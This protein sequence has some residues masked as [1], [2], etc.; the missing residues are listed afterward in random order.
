MPWGRASLEVECLRDGTLDVDLETGE[1]FSVRRGERKKRRLRTDDDGYKSFYLNRERRD[2]RG[3]KEY[4]RKT[5]GFRYRRR[6]LVFVHR[7]V[8][9][10]AIAL[11][12]GGDHNWRDY[13]EDLP[14]GVDVNHFD[15]DRANNR[16]GNL[17]LQTELANRSRRAMTAAELREV[18]AFM[19][20]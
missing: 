1:V 14:R 19:E 9:I 20:S 8:K 12:K 5:K 18:R 4:C 6:R 17:E 13:V 3:G 2:K 11:A 15:R 7:V 16:A 10:K